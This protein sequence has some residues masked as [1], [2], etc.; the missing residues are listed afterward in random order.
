MQ[1]IVKGT[2]A[3]AV[4]TS[5]TLT[6]SYPSNKTPGNFKLAMGHKLALNS[7]ALLSFPNDFDLTFNALASG[8]TVTN[9]IATTWPSGTEFILE[10][11]EIGEDLA[12]S[13]AGGAIPGT[14]EAN[15]LHISLGSPTVASANALSTSA[16]VTAIG[17]GAVLLALAADLIT[18]RTVVAAW[19]NTAIMT[20]TGK[21][22]YGK[23]MV[24]KSA[25]GTSLT[26]KKAFKSVSSVTVSADVTGCTVGHG[27]IFGFPV[28][29]AGAG[30]IVRE[31][32]DGA[33][34]TAGTTAGGIRDAGGSTATTGDVRGT[35]DPNSAADGS[36]QFNLIVMADPNNRGIAQFAG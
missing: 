1:S 30:Y 20:V 21:D 2:L 29:V 11:Q 27:D 3:A 19:T 18:P 9:K 8:I 14:T 6:V 28:F 35:Y 26:G 22:V 32:M 5:G 25:S 13:D 15:L 16:A 36:R 12:Y 34:A 24:E 23:T 4:A 7:G 17:S 10:L 33:L 31:I